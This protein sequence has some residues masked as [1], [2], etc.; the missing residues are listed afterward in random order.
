M[1]D[2][3]SGILCII[4]III[5]IISLFIEGRTHYDINTMKQNTYHIYN[6][7]FNNLTITCIKIFDNK[8]IILYNG[9]DKHSE[10]V[11]INILYSN[12]IHFLDNC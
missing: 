8:I 12:N 7:A 5:I 11:Q 4:I 6:V 10:Y 9:F 2:P 3:F 1:H